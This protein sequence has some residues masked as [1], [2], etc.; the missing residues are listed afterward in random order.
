MLFQRL[1]GSDESVVLNPAGD[2]NEAVRNRR[3]DPRH[4][5]SALENSEAFSMRRLRQRNLKPAEQAFALRQRCAQQ[6]VEPA[7][8]QVL[9]RCLDELIPVISE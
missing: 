3:V 8:A 4:T 7:A 6:A 2:S 5:H 1:A 9:G